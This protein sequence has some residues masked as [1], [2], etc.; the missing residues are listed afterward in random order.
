M[1]KLPRNG[2]I[3]IMIVDGVAVAWRPFKH[4][5]WIKN[6]DELYECSVCGELSC[7]TSVYCGDCGSR[8]DG[9]EI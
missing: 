2:E 4:G 7:C 9:E 6:T 3:T 1:E 5:Y 8:M